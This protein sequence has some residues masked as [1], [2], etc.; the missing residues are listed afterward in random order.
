MGKTIVM[1]SGGALMRYKNE[2]NKL[3]KSKHKFFAFSSS[4]MFCVNELG[5]YPDYFAFIDPNSA[6]SILEYICN[7]KEKIK[8]KIIFLDPLHTKLSYKDYIKWY[9]TTPVGRIDNFGGWKR[10]HELVNKLQKNNNIIN[11]PC[12]TTRYLNNNPNTIISN[13]VIIYKN[14]DTDNPDK[15]TSVVLPLLDRLKIY[16]I[17]LIGFDCVGGRYIH[18][19]G[20][21]YTLSKCPE[22]KNIKEK[23][24]VLPGANR[25]LEESKQSI[26]KFLP[27]WL[28]KFN[29]T[30]LVEDQYTF[31]KNLIPYQPINQLINGK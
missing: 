6:M 10:L 31:L 23:F 4:F 18:N 26:S 27:T 11:I 22:L 13:K 19:L 24:V 3:H 30:N 15:L 1:S 14:S 29:I 25:G 17:S 20:D 7:S 8:T 28:K 9:G 21:E 12:Y 2:L 5:I 16:D